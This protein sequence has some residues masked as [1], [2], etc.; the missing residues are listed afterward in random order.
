MYITYTII[1]DVKNLQKLISNKL[2][3]V[4][5]TELCESNITESNLSEQN[6]C[7]EFALFTVTL[8]A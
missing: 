5:L 7:L 2:C 3:K 6:I 8:F 1:L 4:V